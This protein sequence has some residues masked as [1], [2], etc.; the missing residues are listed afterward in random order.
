MS[1]N[2]PKNKYC[3]SNFDEKF[4]KLTEYQKLIYIAISNVKNRDLIN[5]CELTE[6][7]IR[8]HISKIGGKLGISKKYNIE[9]GI[10][11]ILV[12]LL[13]ANKPYFTELDLEYLEVIFKLIKMTRRMKRTGTPTRPSKKKEEA[14]TRLSEKQK[15]DKIN[16]LIDRLSISNQNRLVY[17]THSISANLKIPIESMKELIISL[18]DG[19][20]NTIESYFNHIPEIHKKIWNYLLNNKYIIS[21]KHELTRYLSDMIDQYIHCLTCFG[22]GYQNKEN[23]AVE[24]LHT[25]LKVQRIV[26]LYQDLKFYAHQIYYSK[27]KLEIDRKQFSGFYVT[28]FDTLNR[29]W[30]NFNKENEIL[31]FSDIYPNSSGKYLYKAVASPLMGGSESQQGVFLTNISFLEISNLL[32]ELHKKNEFQPYIVLEDE[33]KQLVATSYC[34]QAF[35]ESDNK[36]YKYEIERIRVIDSTNENTQI[37]GKALLA[38]NCSQQSK[39]YNFSENGKDYF[40]ISKPLKGHFVSNWL[41]TMIVSEE[42]L[43]SYMKNNRL[44]RNKIIY[45]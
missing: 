17:P 12:E 26:T 29:P 11:P 31:Y 40:A 6:E 13:E 8:Q 18:F 45:Y 36:S 10:K 4:D 38:H 28:K 32:K 14:L 24:R 5:K 37:M 9:S 19:L 44:I 2:F 21:N 35:K 43:I 3:D 34:E 25:G 23:L 7:N 15:K 16:I 20:Q 27:T 22:V 42:N 41:M 39:V 1:N 30:Y 33:K